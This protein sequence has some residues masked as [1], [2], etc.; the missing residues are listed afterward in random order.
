VLGAAR[1]L[2]AT[3]VVSLP[4]VGSTATPEPPSIAQRLWPRVSPLPIRP[5]RVKL[6]D[7]LLTLLADHEL[8][9][10]TMAVRVAASTRADPFAVVL[11]GLGALSG[12][13][14]GSAS[15][16]CHRLLLDAA[17]STPDLAVARVL[18]AQ[19]LVGFGHPVYRDE[20]PRAVHLLGSVRSVASRKERAVVDGVI[21]A[22]GA[23]SGAKPNV[24]LATAAVALVSGMH[25]GATEAIFGL[26][27]TAGWIAHA[28]EEYSEE[29]LR[30]R[31]RA[32]YIGQEDLLKERKP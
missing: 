14:H 32:I 15:L 3:F 28:L 20:D 23:V 29:P 17:A 26:A 4:L 27:R 25:L 30:F 6:L 8:A 24:D 10:S 2:I 1:C 13:F 22:A 18:S 7:A 11:T 16:Q 12:P 31:A 21:A 19:S 9:T 5:A